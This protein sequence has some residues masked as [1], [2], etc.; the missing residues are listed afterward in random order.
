ML[1]LIIL[2]GLIAALFILP[3]LLLIFGF[4][5]VTTD[6]GRF[7]IFIALVML[8]AEAASILIEPFEKLVVRVMHLL[9]LSVYVYDNHAIFVVLILS[10]EY[11]SYK[12]YKLIVKK[13]VVKSE[14]NAS[15]AT[16]WK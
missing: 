9:G 3:L 2:C 10:L 14:D 8:A 7:K 13:A 4:K 12:I 1:A 15:E 6:Q 5:N 11:I 16:Q